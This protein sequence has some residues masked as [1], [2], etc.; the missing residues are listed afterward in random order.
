MGR[1]RQDGMATAFFGACPRGC[2]VQSSHLGPD[3]PKRRSAPGWW[4][5]D[6]GR[7]AGLL[8]GLATSR[9]IRSG[10][11]THA[12][13]TN[14]R[15]SERGRVAA[16]CAAVEPFRRWR[17]GSSSSRHLRHSRSRRPEPP[18]DDHNDDAS[19]TNLVRDEHGAKGSGNRSTPR[20]GGQVVGRGESGLGEAEPPD[21]D[22]Y[23]A[24]DGGGFFRLGLSSDRFCRAWAHDHFER[25]SS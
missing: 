20:S 7:G 16:G 3:R 22:D 13:F 21:S 17:H 1:R 8:T 2:W 24:I 4:R 9:T 10:R 25:R 19:Y 14:H 12:L 23:V 6:P 18:G 5:D 15:S 11:G